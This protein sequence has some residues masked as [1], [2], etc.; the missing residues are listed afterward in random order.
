MAIQPIPTDGGRSRPQAVD[1]D[2]LTIPTRISKTELF[3]A[4]LRLCG[5]TLEAWQVEL[6]AMRAAGAAEAEIARRRGMVPK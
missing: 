2:P 6:A 4:Y 3:A 1:G 5:Y